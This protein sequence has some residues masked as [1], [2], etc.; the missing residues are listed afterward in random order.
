[1]KI[2]V[3]KIPTNHMSCPFGSRDYE[4]DWLWV[5]ELDKRQ[6]CIEYDDCRWLVEVGGDKNEV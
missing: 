1:M 6:C 2:L 4:S 3:D 5:C